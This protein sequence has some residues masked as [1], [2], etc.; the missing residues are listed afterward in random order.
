LVREQHEETPMFD[1]TSWGAVLQGQMAHMGTS[2]FWVGVAQIIW[3]DVILAGDNAVVIALA[4]RNLPPHQRVWGIGIGTGVAVLLRIFFT[5]IV[6]NLM[7]L[8]YVKI[9]GGVALFYIALKLLAHEEEQPDESSIKSSSN[10]WQ[11]VWTVAIADVVMSLDNVLG[12]AATAD[13]HGDGRVPLIIFGLLVSIPLVV[14]GA[15]VVMQLL[16]RYPILVWA[17][18]GL[19]GW[20]AGQVIATDPAVKGALPHDWAPHVEMMAVILGAAFVV[21]VGWIRQRSTDASTPA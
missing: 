10:L 19:L 9:A 17:G 20:I 14:A 6:T 11:A 3:V 5:L 12:I 15:Q 8:P 18:G 13:A 2:G 7:L 16:N 1:L 21:C 4:C